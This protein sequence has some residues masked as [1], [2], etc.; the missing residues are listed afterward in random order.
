MI[1]P[2]VIQRGL[3]TL[4][5][6]LFTKKIDCMAIRIPAAKVM[7]CRK[8][9]GNDLLQEPKI[10]NVVDSDDGAKDKR[11]VL[12]NLDINNEDLAGASESTKKY[13]QEQDYGVVKT[14]FQVGYDHWTADEVLK[15]MLPEEVL[16]EV[17]S[18]F[19]IVGHIA[20]M[21]LREEY[22]PWK[23]LIGQVIKDK[24]PAIRTVVNK[25]DTIDTT[26]RF[27]K[28]E[29]LAGEDDMVAEVRESGC[30]FRFDFSQVYWNS[31]LQNEHERLIKMF[32]PWD[33]VCDVMAGV[34]PFALPAAK[35]GCLVYANDLNP[36]SFKYMTENARLNRLETGGSHNLHLY[37]LDGRDFIRQAVEDLA[38]TGYNAQVAQ[39]HQAAAEKK[40]QEQKAKAKQKKQATKDETTRPQDTQSSPT[41][42]TATTTTAESSTGSNFKT[43]DHFVMN[44]PASAIEFLD[45]F[46]G[47]FKGKEAEI[48]EP[49]RQL[50]MIHCHCF[51]KS[52]EPEKDVKERVEAV[53]GGALDMDSFHLHFVRKVAP[54]KDMFCVSF[55]LPSEIAFASDS[56]RKAS[57]AVSSTNAGGGQTS[58][59]SVPVPDE[60]R[61]RAE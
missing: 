17:P 8:A 57:E 53:M 14:H 52:E 29:V 31:R 27:F 39:Q 12:L 51:S 61:P 43:F 35:K 32:K 10:R 7:E 50:P 38:K 42:A 23:H 44:L 2:P 30:R 13:I 19:T 41:T 48:P 21:N 55:R 9:I 11:L 3:K 36:T 15:A 4:D 18:G 25:T 46:R 37:N 6:A 33:A 24:N 54:N 5:K 59:G 1:T 34:G 22:L 47:L 26:F 16:D 20:H 56:K 40:K 60:K 49:K 28:M 45:A 58:E